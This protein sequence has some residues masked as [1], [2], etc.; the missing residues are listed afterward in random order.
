MVGRAAGNDVHP[1]DGPHIL[2]R[3]VDV[4]QHHAA[5][6]D[7]GG[8]GLADGLRL[9]EDLLQHEV[10]VA[11]L[12]GGGDVPVDSRVLLL[13]D[14]AHL[15][16]Q[17]VHGLRRQDGD[18]PVLQVDHVPGVL[19][20]SRHVGGEEVSLRTEA[21]DQGALLPGGDEGVGVVRADDAQGVGALQPPQDPAHGLQHAAA[22]LIVELQQLGHH[23][24]VGI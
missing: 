11:A 1:V 4:V 18:L 21:Q 12:L 5:L 23:L 16:V 2:L 22:L 20:D 3:H 10:G 8:D 7:A 13:R 9:L 6:P 14:R 17:V 15:G 19:D 24:A